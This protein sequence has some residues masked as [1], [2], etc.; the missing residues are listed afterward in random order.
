M[1]MLWICCTK[2]CPAEK[3]E[4]QNAFLFLTAFGHFFT[5]TT[6]FLRRHLALFRN[7]RLQHTKRRYSHKKNK[8]DRYYSCQKFHCSKCRKKIEL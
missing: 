6:A 1:E 5:L 4:I 2:N 8:I 7:M 3:L